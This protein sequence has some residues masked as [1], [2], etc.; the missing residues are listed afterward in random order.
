[1]QYEKVREQKSERR[2]VQN[3]QK[4]YKYVKKHKCSMYVKYIYI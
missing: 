2:N 3:I 1:M 4:V